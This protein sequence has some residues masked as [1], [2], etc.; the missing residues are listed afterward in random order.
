MNGRRRSEPCA[1]QT[2]D[3]FKISSLN[4]QPNTSVKSMRRSSFPM[5]KCTS[6][7]ANRKRIPFGSTVPRSIDFGSSTSGWN[8]RCS[9]DE[10]L[11]LRPNEK[12]VNLVTNK[13]SQKF[14]RGVGNFISTA[15]KA[16][17]HST[18]NRLYR[19]SQN[20]SKALHRKKSPVFGRSTMPVI[21]NKDNLTPCEKDKGSDRVS[22][23]TPCDVGGTMQ[24]DK[25]CYRMK[26]TLVKGPRKSTVKDSVSGEDAKAALLPEVAQYS[27]ITHTKYFGKESSDSPKTKKHANSKGKSNI[28]SKAIAKK[29]NTSP[30]KS[31]SQVEVKQTSNGKVNINTVNRNL[32]ISGTQ[33][34]KCIPFQEQENTETGLLPKSGCQD[35]ST[36]TVPIDGTSSL[37]A[38]FEDS[39]AG[40]STSENSLESGELKCCPTETQKVKATGEKGEVISQSSSNSSE[41]PRETEEELTSIN[42]LSLAMDTPKPVEGNSFFRENS[43]TDTSYN[44]HFIKVGTGVSTTSS[45]RDTERFSCFAKLGTENT[46]P[47]I[48]ATNKVTTSRNSE[49][50]NY[51]SPEDPVIDTYTFSDKPKLESSVYSVK[52]RVENGI[53]SGKSVKRCNSSVKSECINSPPNAM[54]DN[55]VLAG[56]YFPVTHSE[57]IQT[58]HSL[59]STTDETEVSPVPSTNVAEQCNVTIVKTVDQRDLLVKTPVSENTMTETLP[60]INSIFPAN[61]LKEIKAA[62]SDSVIDKIAI[63][64]TKPTTL[65]SLQKVGLSTSETGNANSQRKSTSDNVKSSTEYVTENVTKSGDMDSNTRNATGQSLKSEAT[66]RHSTARGNLF[67]A[68]Y[69]WGLKFSSNVTTKRRM[70]FS[71]I[72]KQARKNLAEVTSTLDQIRST[73]KHYTRETHKEMTEEASFRDFLHWQYSIRFQYLP[74]KMIFFY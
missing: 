64:L 8:G 7:I 27:S 40:P 33:S 35:S 10:K 56:G 24:N 21:S 17:I 50:E 55:V 14:N 39:T 58:G 38:F 15:T 62:S 18:S 42:K 26:H 25:K 51:V 41:P 13:S 6:N 36:R 3:V 28:L 31:T 59:T 5:L 61:T 45:K 30:R 57:I 69:K 29:E 43:A 72:N 54:N 1:F 46:L 44:R 4:H 32:G 37:E 49:K 71:D 65:E 23:S 63:N 34:E 52:Q 16:G 20:N 22:S 9:L 19:D 60:V 12:L 48:S 66:S 70:S 47:L 74:L 2:E 11:I 53:Y 67:P 73:K 68:S